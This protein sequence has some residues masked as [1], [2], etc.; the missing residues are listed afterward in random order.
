MSET[1]L[2]VGWLAGVGYVRDE[3]YLWRWDEVGIN[4]FGLESPEVCEEG[5]MTRCCRDAKFFL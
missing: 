5:G 3:S 4:G 1:C 2:F